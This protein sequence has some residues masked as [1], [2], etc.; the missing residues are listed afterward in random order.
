MQINGIKIIDGMVWKKADDKAKRAIEGIKEIDGIKR[1]LGQKRQ[2]LV[3]S[4][5]LNGRLFHIDSCDV[6]R[7][8]NFK[9]E[10]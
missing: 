6:F 5:G 2:Q 3:E 10:A 4:A 7:K 1:Q 9:L 8:I